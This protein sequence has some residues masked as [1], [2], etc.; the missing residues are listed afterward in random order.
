MSKRTCSIEGCNESHS[1][2]GYCGPHYKRWRRGEGANAEIHR[3]R[4]VNLPLADAFATFIPERDGECLLWPAHK[5]RKGYGTFQLGNRN[6]SAHRVSYEIANGPIPDGLMVDHICRQRSCVN[7]EH[8]RLVTNKQNIENHG[9][10]P[11]PGNTSGVRGV[12]WA[13]DRQKWRGQVMHCGR[14]ISVGSFDNVED[15]EAAVR[16]LRRKLFTHNDIDRG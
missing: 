5:N 3:R 1:A 7:P 12:S 6:L 10:A 14:N 16:E 8:L 15:A 11:M 4:P 9:G 2:R 13:N